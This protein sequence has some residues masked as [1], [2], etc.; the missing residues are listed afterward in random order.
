[1]PQVREEAYLSIGEGAISP[2]ARLE[3]GEITEEGIQQFIEA[4]NDDSNYLD[5]DASQVPTDCVDGRFRKDGQARTGAEAAAGT[6]SVVM[7]DALTNGSYRRSG[8]QAP[9]HVKRVFGV[10]QELGKE[11]GGHD[12]DHAAGANC[13]CGAEDRLDASDPHAPSILGYIARRGTE[14]QAVLA[15]LG[16][17]VSDDLNTAIMAQATHLREDGYAT[18]GAELRAATKEVAGEDSIITLT[19]THNEIV[20]NINMRAGKVLDR[21][22]LAERF[23]DKYQAF[24]VDVMALKN[25]TDSISL[26][27]EEAHKKLVAALYYNVATAAVL[28]H[29]SLRVNA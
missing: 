21:Q 5:I 7:A 26:T 17:E 1:M 6:F 23:G 18:G 28:S 12:D 11:V 24:N 20:V 10:L 2:Q 9:A 3:A 16:V 22:K 15:T 27:E 29:A 25:G 13:G 4:L 8:E 19:G 14:I